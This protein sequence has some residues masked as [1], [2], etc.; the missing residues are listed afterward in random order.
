MVRPPQSPLRK[1]V[2]KR[3]ARSSGF[4]TAA[5]F[6]SQA[7]RAA[8]GVEKAV[9]ILGSGRIPILFGRRERKSEQIGQGREPVA[10]HSQTECGTLE[11][12]RRLMTPFGEPGTN[13]GG[14]FGR[15]YIYL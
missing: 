12:A 15:T 7:K 3:R 13:T 1:N 9:P 8:H 14:E 5:V 6:T 2:N 11:K 4:A 10:A